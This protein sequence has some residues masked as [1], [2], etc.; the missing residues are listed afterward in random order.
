MSRFEIPEKIPSFV[1]QHLTL[2]LESN[3]EEGHMWQGPS[4]MDPVPTL[5]LTTLGHLSKRQR[6]MPLIYGKRGADHIVVASKGGAP[7]HPAWYLNLEKMPEVDVQVAT[8]KFRA[9]ARTAKGEERSLLWDMMS[10]I[11]SPYNDY[12]KAAR[13]REIPV[14]VLETITP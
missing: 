11:F 6:I 7:A 5:L 14:V 8:E 1:K 2:Y 9:R 3:G 4:G 12:Q 10:E 13:S